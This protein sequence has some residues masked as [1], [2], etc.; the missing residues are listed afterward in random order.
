MSEAIS[1]L[2][3]V[4]ADQLKDLYSAETLIAKALPKMAKAASSAT[5]KS[6]FEQHLKQ[7]KVHVERIKSVCA[8][9]KIKPTGKTCQAT[10]GLVKEGDEAISEDATPEMKDL[11]L[12]AAARR[13]EHYEMSGYTSACDLAKALGLSTALKTLSLTLSEETATDAK[14]AKATGPATSKALAAEKAAAK[15]AAKPADPVAAV[16]KAIK[17]VVKKITA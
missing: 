6:G 10:V 16:G 15:Q 9:L 8:A 7:T 17:T 5:L 13:V 1:S 12:I 3:D 4:L 11:L 2:H 14:L